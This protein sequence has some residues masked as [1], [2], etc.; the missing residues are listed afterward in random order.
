MISMSGS[1]CNGVIVVCEEVLP[2]ELSVVQ[3]TRSGEVLEVFMVS[4]D[5]DGD[6]R[7]L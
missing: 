1:I 5:F 4:Y 3:D 6:F 2:A 7:P